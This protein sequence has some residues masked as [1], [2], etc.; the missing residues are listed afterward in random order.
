MNAPYARVSQREGSDMPLQ[1]YSVSS[2]SEGGNE[3]EDVSFDDYDDALLE[4]DVDAELLK[5]PL[6]VNPTALEAIATTF[7]LDVPRA[8][9]LVLPATAP[10]HKVVFELRQLGVDAHA[11]DLVTNGTCRAQLL[12]R[13]AGVVAE[14]PTLL[15]STLAT[16]RGI[17]FPELSHVFLLGLPQGRDGDAYLHIAGRVGRFGRHGKVITVLEERK[18]QEVRKGK[19][20]VKDEPKKMSVILSRIGIAPT[21]LA[22]FD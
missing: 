5:S 3:D 6:G 7:A 19:V 22:H 21:R 12:S 8:A 11:L 14:N 1:A 4:D 2:T 20:V 10:V 18:E 13:N 9:L 16:T 15:V 17:D